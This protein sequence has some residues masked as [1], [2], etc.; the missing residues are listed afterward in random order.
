M[1]CVTLWKRTVHKKDSGG[2]KYLLWPVMTWMD[3]THTYLLNLW[4]LKDT[5]TSAPHFSSLVSKRKSWELWNHN[6]AVDWRLCGRE[7]APSFPPFA[8][9]VTSLSGFRPLPQRSG[10]TRSDGSK[11][12][13]YVLINSLALLRSQ[14]SET[15]AGLGYRGLLWV[16]RGNFENWN[17]ARSRPCRKATIFKS[18]ASCQCHVSS[19][20]CPWF[21]LPG[22]AK[23]E[24]TKSW[25][26]HIFQF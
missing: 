23:A 11:K 12:L 9:R 18:L 6:G 2:Q 1:L 25:L 17:W 24:K 20:S 3:L 15:L 7:L 26:G 4:P 5:S 14:C 10:I 13:Y 22:L 21:N 16:G 8:T 19:S